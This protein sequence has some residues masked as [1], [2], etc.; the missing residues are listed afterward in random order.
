VYFGADNRPWV[1]YRDN[2]QAP[3]IAT[4]FADALDDCVVYLDEAHTR[5]VDLK[6]PRRARGALTLALGQT[7]DHT[8]QGEPPIA[9]F[10][11]FRSALGIYQG[12]Q[13]TLMT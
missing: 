12:V 2:K 13:L 9:C 1:Y 4:P 3:L 11:R 10:H 8:V 7:K 5:G 6:F